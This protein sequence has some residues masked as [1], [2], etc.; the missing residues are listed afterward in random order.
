MCSRDCHLF[1]LVTQLELRAHHI[2]NP[3]FVFRATKHRASQSH[4]LAFAALCWSLEF[5]P[6]HLWT[7]YLNRLHELSLIN[8]LMKRHRS[9]Q[10]PNKPCLPTPPL[11][12]RKTRIRRAKRLGLVLR[13]LQDKEGQPLFNIQAPF[14]IYDFGFRVDS[15]LGL[16]SFK[17]SV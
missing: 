16:E 9:P 6:K 7:F 3:P 8:E 11:Y 4:G 12:S 17:P 13:M 14:R 1:Q 5:K 10:R 2:S 15:E